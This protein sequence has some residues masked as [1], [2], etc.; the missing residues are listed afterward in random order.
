[1]QNNKSSGNNGLTK[2]FYSSCW[3]ELNRYLLIQK[4]KQNVRIN[5]VFRKASNNQIKRKRESDKRYVK[6]WNPNS[7]L[8][9][10]AK[11]ISKA[12]SET[13]SFEKMID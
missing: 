8:S 6:N 9:I 10:D 11:M 13:D 12:L 4:S 1:M 2:E 5:Q 7:L 3:L